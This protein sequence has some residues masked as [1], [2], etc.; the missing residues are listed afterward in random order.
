MV[1]HVQLGGSVGSIVVVAFVVVGGTVVGA[2]VV[3]GGAVVGALV[4]VGG[5]VVG[6]GFASGGASPHAS[7]N[8]N[9]TSSTATKPF[10]LLPRCT[11]NWNCKIT[12]F[13]SHFT[14]TL[15]IEQIY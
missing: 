2:L 9:S 7:K 15:P 4:V 1:C 6:M 12:Y 8:R 14:R 10:P 3:V 11:I 13:I 5:I